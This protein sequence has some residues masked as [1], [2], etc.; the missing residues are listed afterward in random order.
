MP[1]P[2]SSTLIRMS[3]PISSALTEILLRGVLEGV[4]QQ[5]AQGI[6]HGLAVEVDAQVFGQ[7]AGV[8][9]HFQLAAEQADGIDFVSQPFGE[10]DAGEVRFGPSRSKRA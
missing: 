10:F 1:I 5:I 9:S 4:A 3:S 2:S 7:L 8:D 6:G